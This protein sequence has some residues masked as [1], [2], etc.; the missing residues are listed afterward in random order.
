[1]TEPHPDAPTGGRLPATAD[2]SWR[3]Q[4]G[5]LAA[6]ALVS[7]LVFWF[8]D[9]DLKVAGRFYHAAAP[10]NP[11][12]GESNPLWQFFYY[13]AP[14]FTA[15]LALGALA[16]LLLGLVRGR[17]SP[18]RRPAA[19]F[20][21]TLV[22]GPGLLVNLVFKENWGR[23]RPRQVEQFAGDMHY[24]PPL[25]MG[26]TREGKSFVAGHASVGFSLFAFWFVWWRSRPRLAWA[27]LG[28]ATL[29]GLTMG[30]GRMAAGAH[31]LSDVLWSGYITF[32]SALLL[33]YFVLREQPARKESATPGPNPLALIG[34]ALLGG[35]MLLGSLVS[36]PV[37]EDIDFAPAPGQRP[38]AA[39]LV[40]DLD[41]ARLDI[42]LSPPDATRP[43][44]VTGTIRGFGL[45]TYQ[46]KSRGQRRGQPE[47]GF[48]SRL[49]QQGFF[50][51]LDTRVNVRLSA[52]E[53]RRLR[54][55]LGQGDIRVFKESGAVDPT[56]ELHTGKGEVLLPAG[57]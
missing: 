17:S 46:I 4:L 38:L 32:F 47:P 13:G 23:P 22:L 48:H 35:A 34:Y 40:L 6:L 1:M 50:A 30:L 53:V 55:R 57:R 9:L 51:E 43:L 39:D 11:W 20:L 26:Q 15:M 18:W 14:V 37:T 33:H 7:T 28:A 31:F 8:T 27:F 5:L 52:P 45:P 12:P 24:L 2:P 54:V 41:Q 36:L 3:L 29:L 21:L 42:H 10:D 49:R 19:L 16:T 44:Q 25:Q 56:L